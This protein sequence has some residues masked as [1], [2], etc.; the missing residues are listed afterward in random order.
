MTATKPKTPAPT[1]LKDGK[2]QG[3]VT[4]P[5]HSYGEDRLRS[6]GFGGHR[7]LDDP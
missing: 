1:R 6:G 7:T 5:I 3:T 2:K 4:P